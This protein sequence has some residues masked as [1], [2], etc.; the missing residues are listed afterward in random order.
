MLRADPVLDWTALMVDGI[1]YDTTGPTLSTRNLAILSTAMYDAVNSV[2]RTHQPYRYLLDPPPDAYPE[3]AAV[4]AAYAVVQVLYPGMDAPAANLCQQFLDSQPATAALTNSLAFGQRVGWT[5]L[6]S[7]GDDGSATQ[8]PYIPSDLPGQWR[9]TPPFYR[10]PLDPQWRYVT[11]FALPDIEPFVPP[12]PPALTSERY[13]EDLNQVKTLGEKTSTV[14]TAEQTQIAVFWSDFSYTAMP[15][16]H[17]HEIAIEIARSRHN[18]LAENARLFALLSVAQAD[19]AIVCWE[20]KFRH[21]FW[22]PV[23][24][25]Q[26]ADEDDNPATEAAPNWQQLLAAPPFPEYTSGHSTFSKASATVLT[27]FYG[28]D[29]IEFTATSDSLPGVT[30]RYTS[31]AACADEIGMSRI[32]GG[33]HFMSANRDG[34][35]C[36]AKIATYVLQNWLLPVQALPCLALETTGDGGPRFRAHGHPGRTLVI[37]MSADLR[38]WTPISTNTAVTGGFPIIDPRTPVSEAV[39]YRAREL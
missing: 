2:E 28:T 5:I 3:A 23:T 17:W 1:R 10:P 19:A 37:D 27:R 38:D 22:R 32:Y 11:P 36:G 18:T 30:R 20:A 34:K 14:R 29:Q 33:I 9:R 12:G 31:F 35:A 24:A 21:N 4:G 8:V 25:I 7:R 15:P 16:G 6:E 13:A 26:R 39:F